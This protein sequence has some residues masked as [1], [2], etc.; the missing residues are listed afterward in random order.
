[1][2]L[3]LN[4]YELYNKDGIEYLIVDH[5]YDGGKVI[6]RGYKEECQDVLEDLINKQDVEHDWL[7]M[8]K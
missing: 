4:R 6:F 3:T 7:E 2:N 8:Y 5:H 1:M